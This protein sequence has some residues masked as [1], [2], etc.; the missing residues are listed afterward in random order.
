MARRLLSRC[1][2]ALALGLMVMGALIGIP[3]IIDPPPRD[4]TA[5]CREAEGRNTRPRK[6]NRSP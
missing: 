6:R 4:A 3:I 1:L 2:R 5:D